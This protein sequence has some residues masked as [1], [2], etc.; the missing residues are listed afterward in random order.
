MLFTVLRYVKTQKGRK[1]GH[2]LNRKNNLI[3]LTTTL[4][5]ATLSF[6]L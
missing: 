3:K 5:T 1:Q 4:S 2:N 6:A